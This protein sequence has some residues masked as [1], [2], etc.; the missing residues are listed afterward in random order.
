MMAMAYIEKHENVVE[1]IGAY[2]DSMTALKIVS[3]LL[4]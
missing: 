3:L 2:V 1:F 4:C